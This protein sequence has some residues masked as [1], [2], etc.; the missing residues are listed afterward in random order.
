MKRSLT[1]IGLLTVLTVCLCPSLRAQGRSVYLFGVTTNFSDSVA[2]V[3]PVQRL[4]SVVLA[5]GTG[6]LTG[7]SLYSAQL[8]QFTERALGRHHDV[9]AVFF[10]KSQAAVEKKRQKVLHHLQKEKD[11]Y[12]K[13]LASEQFRFM[14]VTQQQLIEH[15]HQ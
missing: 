11:Y 1:T 10:D 13:E 8:K 9:P 2:Y 15:G 14:T 7:R 3:T 4:D 12:V 5:K 6:F